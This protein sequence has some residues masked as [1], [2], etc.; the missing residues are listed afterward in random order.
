MDVRLT[1]YDMGGRSVAVLVNGRKEA[2][3]H[4]TTFDGSA[5][6]S[7]IYFCR[8]RAEKFLG[9]DKLVLLR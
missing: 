7:G 5:L 4:Q 6:P 8:L 2:G 1:V 3:V 9:T